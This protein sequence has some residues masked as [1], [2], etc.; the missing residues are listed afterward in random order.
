TLDESFRT[1]LQQKARHNSRVRFIDEVSHEKCM[2]YMHESDVVISASRDEPYSLVIA[3][4]LCMGK[5]CLVSNKTGIAELI[6]EGKNGFVFASEDVRH[7]GSKIS[8]IVQNRDVLTDIAT[9]ARATYEKHLTLSIFEKKVLN[10]LNNVKD[11]SPGTRVPGE[12][13]FTLFK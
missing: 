4:A 10:Y 1:M 9:A 7:L 11:A 6:E 8:G 12:A 3:E 2:E 13:S 5:T